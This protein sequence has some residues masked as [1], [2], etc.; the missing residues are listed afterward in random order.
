MLTRIISG[1]CYVVLLV[2][3]FLLR[4]FVYQ[5]LFHILTWF[6]MIMGSFEVARALKE[7][8]IKGTAIIAVVFSCLAVPL[9]CIIEYLVWQGWAWMFVIDLAIVFAIV[10]AV[11]SL[12]KGYEIKTF[13]VSLLPIV[14][15]ALLL[16]IMLLMNDMAGD[17]GFIALLLSYVIA[18]LSDTFAYF[19]GSLIGGKKLCPKLSPKK[20]WSG[21]I[22]GV[23][24]GALGSMAVWFI[25]TPTINF[26]SPVLLFILLGLVA[27]VL[28]I[29]GDLFESFIKRRV[30][31]KDMGKIMP[32][33]GGVMDRIDGMLFASVLIYF[34]LL[35][36]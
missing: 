32:G 2:A 8:T 9:Y 36:V 12:S 33:H 27:S 10:F 23:I 31:I 19:T 21:A 26:F 7:Y 3:F 17:K 11:I 24:G 15:P 35:L 4:Q 18:P 30:G 6:M 20:T 16:L 29:I 34:V 25:F 5:P 14:Y 22:G 13:G 1:A 28:T